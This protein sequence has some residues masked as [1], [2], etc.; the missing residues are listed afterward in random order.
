MTAQWIVIENTPGY[1]PDDDDPFITDDYSAAVAYLNE[2][3][4]EYADIIGDDKPVYRVEYGWASSGNYAA[5]MIW[6]DSR[7]HDLGRYIGV[8]SYDE[9]G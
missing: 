9:E 8:E 1:M 5:A 7:T 6:D 2:R 3:C 4:E